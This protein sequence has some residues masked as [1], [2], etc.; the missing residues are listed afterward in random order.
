MTDDR[1][2]LRRMRRGSQSAA[3][4]L[5]TR[6]APGLLLYARSMLARG[7]I[8]AEDAVQQ[9]FCRVFELPTRRIREVRDVRA[10]L[11]SVVRSVALNALRGEHRERTRRHGAWRAGAAV[12]SEGPTDPSLV[13]AMLRL[14]LEHREAVVLRHLAGLTF[15]QMAIATAENRSTIAS[16]YR[17]AIQSLREQLSEATIADSPPCTSGEMCCA[18]SARAT[19]GEARHA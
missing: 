15:D 8:D 7:P 4:Q 18:P 9:A 13:S 11:A 1:T 2:L 19:I 17:A 5:W 14:S 16:R 3:T 6:H 12:H 10:W